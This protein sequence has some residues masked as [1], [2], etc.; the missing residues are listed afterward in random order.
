MAEPDVVF[1]VEVTT[2]YGQPQT[3]T[4]A[5]DQDLVESIFEDVVRTI[6]SLNRPTTRAIAFLNPSVTYNTSHVV[7]I[8]TIFE[9]PED[10]I[11]RLVQVGLN[12][13]RPRPTADI[14]TL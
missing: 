11:Q 9:G 6:H 12:I 5:V 14:S 4:Y 7:K 2:T 1:K 13:S 8:H 10:R 3:H